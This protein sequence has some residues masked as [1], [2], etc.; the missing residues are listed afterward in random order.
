MNLLSVQS[1]CIYPLP[2]DFKLPLNRHIISSITP[3][4]NEDQ[5]QYLSFLYYDCCLSFT[6]STT[7]HFPVFWTKHFYRTS[8]FIDAGM[9][10]SLDHCTIKTFFTSLAKKHIVKMC[11]SWTSETQNLKEHKSPNYF[12]LENSEITSYDASWKDSQ[13]LPCKFTLN[14][15]QLL[16]CWRINSKATWDKR[17]VMSSTISSH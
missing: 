9:C 14:H 4:E 2:L 5:I 15:M 10:Y 8:L 7:Y 13:A 11:V 6:V 12:P 16:H 3:D 1:G 17:I